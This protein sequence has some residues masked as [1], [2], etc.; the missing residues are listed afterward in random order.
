VVDRFAVWRDGA[1]AVFLTPDG[2]RVVSDRMLRGERPWV[3]PVPRPRPRE[4]PARED[5]GGTEGTA[6][7]AEPPEE[8]PGAD[9]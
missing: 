2:A 6:D 5:E 4:A 9:Q 8:L 1:Q 7:P 3:P